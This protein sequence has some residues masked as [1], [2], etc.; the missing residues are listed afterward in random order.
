MAALY[1]SA[2]QRGNALDRAAAGQERRRDGGGRKSVEDAPKPGPHA[3]AEDLFLP[4]VA[5]ARRDHADDLADK[6]RTGIAVA[7][8]P[9]GAFLEIDDH[10]HRKA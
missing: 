9:F 2:G 6:L 10:R 4:L 3:V 8:L 1:D 5:N 7:D